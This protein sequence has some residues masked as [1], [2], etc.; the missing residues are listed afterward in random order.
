MKKLVIAGFIFLMAT[1]ASAQKLPS[2]SNYQ[3]K[4][5]RTASKQPNLATHKKARI[6][7]T[8]LR[9]A[10]KEGINFAG[11][12]GLTTWGCGTSCIEAAII[13]MRTGKV[14]FPDVLQ[15]IGA[16]FCELPDDAETLVYTPN[17]RLII[18]SGFKG[19]AQNQSNR[20]CGIYYLEW[21]G[22]NFRQIKYVPKKSSL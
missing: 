3:V 10:A 20:K 9:N 19:G 1:I 17:S 22:A 4:V 12:Y 15:G 7:R 8:N 2:F 16:G 14:F 18:L 13:D 6:F 5:A 21:T 11:H